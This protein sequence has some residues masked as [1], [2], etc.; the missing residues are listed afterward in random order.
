[1][2][3]LE[4]HLRLWNARFPLKA[5]DGT[6]GHMDADRRSIRQAVTIGVEQFGSADRSLPFAPE[7]VSELNEALGALGYETTLRAETRMDSA[8]LQAV[9]RDHMAGTDAAGFLV[10]HVLTHGHLTDGK[11]SVILLGSDEK[12]DGAPDVGQWL[13]SVQNQKTSLPTTLFLLDVCYSGTAAR[14]SWQPAVRAAQTRGW[15]IAACRGDEAAY[16]G[17]FT[18]AVTHVLKDLAVGGLGVHWS[19]EHVPLDIV[20]KAIQREVNRLVRA[21]EN[22]RAQQVTAS[23]IDISDEFPDL[24]FFPNPG[25]RDNPLARV[26][27]RLDPGLAPFVDDL[28]LMGPDVGGQLL[29][30]DEELAR[31]ARW[32][33]ARDGVPLQVVTGGPGAGKS[34]L[35]RV[36]VCAAHPALRPHTEQVWGQIPQQVPRL[37]KFAAVHARGLDLSAI[38]QSL[39]W[40]LGLTGVT[41]A[42]HLVLGIRSL[43]RP[44]IVIDGFD[45]AAD[46]EELRESLLPKLFGSLRP[47]ALAQDPEAASD[48]PTARLLIALRP[49]DLRFPDLL[50]HDERGFSQIV[51]LDLMN[52]RGLEDAVYRYVGDQLRDTAYRHRGQ[53][54]GG[55][56]TEVARALSEEGHDAFLLAKLYTGHFLRTQPTPLT[57]PGAAQQFG[58]K[59]PRSLREMLDLDLARADIP[60]LRGVM[61]VLAH[62][63]GQGMPLTVLSRLAS[64]STVDVRNALVVGQAYLR[65][66]RDTDGSVLY[67]ISDPG[68]ADHLR[69]AA[70]RRLL[71]QLLK[72]LGPSEARNW[73]AA[74]PYVLRHA[75]DHARQERKEADLRDDPGFLLE[76]KPEIVRR[77]LA[78]S[79]AIQDVYERSLDTSVNPPR[80]KR[81][82]LALNAMRE[83]L[84]GLAERIGSVP[85][86]PPLDWQP[87]W[88]VGEK[89]RF[90]KRP[91]QAIR[92][93][94]IAEFRRGLADGWHGMEVA[95]EFAAPH[96]GT[97]AVFLGGDHGIVFAVELATGREITSF[98]SLGGQAVTAIR[99]V[100]IA[101]KPLLVVANGRQRQAIDLLSRQ[102]IQAGSIDDPA[103]ALTPATS[104]LLVL[105]G[106]LVKVIGGSDGQVTVQTASSAKPLPERHGRGLTVVAS[107]YFL[108]RPLAFTGGRDAKVR[109]WDLAGLQL[110]DVIDMP[111]RVL[112]IEATREGDLVVLA[113]TEAMAFRHLGTEES[114]VERN[115]L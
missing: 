99:Y 90:L 81:D 86:E 52:S 31:L 5:A 42:D 21:D 16:D 93:L 100:N 63:S 6:G 39:A 68:L 24:P 74:E 41:S 2:P 48:R 110:L 49:G 7:R 97:K 66:A 20:A 70:D 22:A 80:V 98:P 46:P 112:A 84:E 33:S 36:L 91:Q 34:A 105:D 76:A 115:L 79:G 102:V 40:Q 28:L 17:R 38:V 107:Q 114:T 113:G 77:A 25:Y 9:I 64:A 14:L 82:A 92:A 58:A 18:V 32:M 1:M 35:L 29:G 103:L 75:F 26:R 51:D 60:L 43:P 15:V 101:G 72:A 11:A 13:D 96:P 85:G 109:I 61:T 10:V 30:R 111:G 53:H 67:K 73:R 69:R 27:D 44:L 55:F 3:R 12:V 108:G 8:A 88:V 19:V 57:D 23:L 65:Q 37:D 106:A 56:A 87:R 95:A 89:A 54:V 94:T 45:E 47:V 59:V 50:C 104:S 78:G 4:S 71:D 83:G 62:A